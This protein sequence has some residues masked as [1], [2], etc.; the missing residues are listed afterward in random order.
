MSSISSGKMNFVSHY[1]IHRSREINTLYYIVGVTGKIG[2][3][4]QDSVRCEDL[5][6]TVL[7]KP[8][9]E[10]MYLYKELDYEKN[11]KHTIFALGIAANIKYIG[12]LVSPLPDLLPFQLFFQSREQVIVLR[13]QI[14]RIGWVIKT[15]EALVGQFL[16]GC[17]CLVSRFRPCR[18]KDL[19]APGKDD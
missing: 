17:K 13:G 9:W 2:Y 5:S 14:R 8:V 16:L 18:A 15:L 7:Q 4:L 10:V 1:S 11:H 3:E 19:S 6:F 12:M